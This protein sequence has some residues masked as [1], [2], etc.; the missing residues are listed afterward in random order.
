VQNSLIKYV[1]KISNFLFFALEMVVLDVLDKK[2]R[3]LGTIE[4][5]K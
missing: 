5:K 3:G 1:E 2:K 4:V